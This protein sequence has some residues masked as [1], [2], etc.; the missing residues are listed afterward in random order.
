MRLRIDDLRSVQAAYCN[1]SDTEQAF[2]D[3]LELWLKQKYKVERFGPPT[4]RMSVEAVDRKTGG[5]NHDLAKEIASDHPATGIM[6]NP[7]FSFA[8]CIC[9]TCIIILYVA[10]NISGNYF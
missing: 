2:S 7:N 10:K 4:W 9:H 5:N 8:S 3:T 1:E 6:D